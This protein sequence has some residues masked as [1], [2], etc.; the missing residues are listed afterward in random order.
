MEAIAQD[1]HEKKKTLITGKT[2][3]NSQ[4]QIAR[5]TA[6]DTVHHTAFNDA[7]YITFLVKNI[8]EKAVDTATIVKLANL[9]LPYAGNNNVSI[10]DLISTNFNPKIDT[11][12][13]KYLILKDRYALGEWLSRN[14]N[15]GRGL[16]KNN[17]T[18]CFQEDMLLTQNLINQH[19]TIKLFDS[20]SNNLKKLDSIKKLEKIPQVDTSIQSKIIREVIHSYNIL[21]SVSDS[22]HQINDSS[23]AAS[24]SNI[25]TIKLK[26]K[27]FDNNSTTEINKFEI[28]KKNIEN[29]FYGYFI[30]DLDPNDRME[31]LKITK[32]KLA[33]IKN[34]NIINLNSPIETHTTTN[35]NNETASLTNFK[36]PSQSELIDALAIYM[37]TR[38]KQD[39]VLTFVNALRKYAV[40]QPLLTDMFPSTFK[41]LNQSPDYEVPRFG[42]VW[43]HAIAED[44]TTIPENV[45]KGNYI[46]QDNPTIMSEPNYKLFNDVVLIS[47]QVMLKTSFPDMVS[48]FNLDNTLL[49][50]DYIKNAFATLQ[51]VDQE[52]VN[53]RKREGYWINWS[54]DLNSLDPD[55]LEVFVGLLHMRYD[56]VFRHFKLSYERGN[57]DEVKN[58]ITLRNYLSKILIILSGFEKSQSEY[59]KNGRSSNTAIDFWDMQQNLFTALHDVNIVNKDVNIDGYINLLTT[60]LSI[61]KDIEQKNYAA[62]VH[63]SIEVIDSLVPKSNQYS[64]LFVKNWKV[65]KEKY[66]ESYVTIKKHLDAI[67]YILSKKI[68]NSQEH[69]DLSNLNKQVDD[70][71]H[72][73]KTNEKLIPRLLVFSNPE[74]FKHNLYNIYCKID[75]SASTVSLHPQ[76]NQTY[77]VTKFAEFF[78]DMLSAQNNKDMA[79][80]IGTYAAPPNS[81]VIKRRTRASI[82]LNSYIGTYFGVE[83]APSPKPVYGLTAPIGLT[84][85]WGLHRK[86]PNKINE[87]TFIGRDGKLQTLTGSSFSINATIIDIGAVVSYRLSNG[88]DKALPQKITF[89][90]FLSPGLSC[91]FGIKNVPLCIT[92]GFEFTPQLRNFEDLSQLHS[93]SRIYA[94]VYYDLPLLNIS[95]R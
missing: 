78:T 28:E 41:L 82:S 14:K 62:M 24:E 35:A 33:L 51:M 68:K 94:G 92:T 37:V 10:T 31:F 26:L 60:C 90:Q 55:E 80:V 72:D 1:G 36:I 49:K 70:I 2:A 76:A 12:I 83:Y 69:I 17:I 5:D 34:T 43:A 25:A 27:I 81:Y 56:S 84:F 88:I 65:G 19:V 15:I 13:Q 3:L 54:Q 42:K 29:Y 4:K 21:K 7:K 61:Y 71:F 64:S 63:E 86:T 59:L 38:F 66:E 30:K 93:A 58:R 67:D 11:L 40:K 18:V 89:A 53:T 57:I 32:Q 22:S 77:Y 75:A 46:T 23:V 52:L 45:L 85:S 8:N 44:L 50:N 47:K 39:A 6:L 16:V 91:S 74:S 95:K 79:S 9:I 73:S 87:D 48:Y 20:I